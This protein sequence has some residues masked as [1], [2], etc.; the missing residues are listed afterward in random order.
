MVSLM[1]SM[2][3]FF[4]SDSSLGVSTVAV[5]NS[6]TYVRVSTCVGTQTWR[7]EANASESV[8]E[9]TCQ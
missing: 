1:S 6:E 3:L 5:S 9:G 2:R 4:V 8:V 7:R